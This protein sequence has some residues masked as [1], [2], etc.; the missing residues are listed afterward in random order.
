MQHHIITK[1]TPS[2]CH[3]KYIG[4]FFRLQIH[5]SSNHAPQTLDK[6][7]RNVARLAEWEREKLSIST[8][9]QTKA[10][11]VMNAFAHENPLDY[12]EQ[13]DPLILIAVV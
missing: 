8:S 11:I 13:I 3:H 2:H 6:K 4:A 5:H 1:T 7:R 12:K 10:I 9:T